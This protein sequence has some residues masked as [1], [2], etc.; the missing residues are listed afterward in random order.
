MKVAV[1]G[2]SGAMGMGIARHLSKNY[3]V[4][5]GSRDPSRA[6]AAASEWEA[7]RGPTTREPQGRRT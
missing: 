6:V 5:I 1:I 2:G 3:Q 4:I 7:H